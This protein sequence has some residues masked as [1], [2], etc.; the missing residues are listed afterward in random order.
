MTVDIEIEHADGK[1]EKRSI[2]LDRM[3]NFG[4][5]TR[6]PDD[7]VAHQE[8]VAKVGVGIA[9]D[10]PAPRV[11]PI[12]P[13]NLVTDGEV[14]IHNAETSG[15]VEIVILHDG[16]E[17]FIGVGSDHTDR[18]LERTSIVW[19]KQAY[20]NVLAPR[21]WPIADLRDHWDDL[22]LRSWVDGR[23]YQDVG[24][25]IFMHPDEML[26]NLADRIPDLP[27]HYILYS[28][29]YV[30]VDKSLGFGSEWRFELEDPTLGRA[31]GHSY[32]LTNILAEIVEGYRVPLVG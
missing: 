22:V 26:A 6:N 27:A 17:L 30:S 7:A 12:S 29:T 32:R 31:I 11:Y 25:N 20:P 23:P 21:L 19:S 18:Q 9:F 8:E 3:Y 16:G 4:S 5:A 14:F 24:V 15:E 1:I 28:G 13:H 10:I 2:T